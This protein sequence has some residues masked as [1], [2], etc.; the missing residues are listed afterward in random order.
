MDIHTTPLSDTHRVS[1][2]IITYVGCGV[3]IVCLL[4]AIITFQFFRGLKVGLPTAH[5]F[6]YHF[7]LSAFKVD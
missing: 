1:L 4:L 3:S 2:E 6:F 5:S 7:I